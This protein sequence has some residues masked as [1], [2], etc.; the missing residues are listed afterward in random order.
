MILKYLNYYILN[1][2]Q[3]SYTFTVVMSRFIIQSIC[4][5]WLFFVSARDVR[6][7]DSVC[8]TNQLPTANGGCRTPG[9]V[10]LQSVTTLRF[11]QKTTTTHRRSGTVDSLRCRGTYC[12]KYAPSVV[13]CENS[14][15]DSNGEVRWACTADGLDYRLQL[16]GEDVHCEGYDHRADTAVLE[17]SCGLEHT[18]E[19]SGARAAR[20][21]P[22]WVR[23]SGAYSISLYKYIIAVA[24]ASVCIY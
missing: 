2:I 21:D 7:E 8:P 13:V 15:V 19:P 11:E 5:I 17:G 20:P 1:Q 24:V 6:A 22:T 12:E 9:A 4:L 18:L 3:L 14:G 16:A 10:N 23:S